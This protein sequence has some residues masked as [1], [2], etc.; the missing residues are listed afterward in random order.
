MS[1]FVLSPGI[2]PALISAISIEIPLVLGLGYA[3]YRNRGFEVAVVLNALALSAIKV[4]TDYLDFYD[5]LVAAAGLL[6]GFA[7]GGTLARPGA[8]LTRPLR[9]LLDVV[10]GYSILLGALKIVT[11][12]YDP[13]DTFLGAFAVVA[14]VILLRWIWTRTHVRSGA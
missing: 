1:G 2:T 5:M 8:S 10:A 4:Y 12:P 9:G 13:F 3:F 14:S 11:D 7:L 6:S